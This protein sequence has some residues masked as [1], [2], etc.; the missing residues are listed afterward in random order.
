[1]T[2]LPIALGVLATSSGVAPRGFERN[3]EDLALG[4]VLP[5]AMGA[6]LMSLSTKSSGSTRNCWAASICDGHVNQRATK[7]AQCRLFIAAE[8]QLTSYRSRM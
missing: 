6:V 5:A 1:M 4:V 3:R 2:P 7:W 8:E